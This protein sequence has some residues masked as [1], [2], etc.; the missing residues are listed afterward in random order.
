MDTTKRG[1]TL[2]SGAVVPK[3]TAV[4][5]QGHVATLHH[6]DGIKVKASTAARLCGYDFPE[7][8]QIEEWCLDSVCEAL[9]GCTVE[10][11]G[12][13]QHG[14]PSWLVVLGMM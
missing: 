10:P 2:K 12:E 11:D 7:P 1:V 5:F 14:R 4:S 9:D 3:G 6:G 13:C 8:E